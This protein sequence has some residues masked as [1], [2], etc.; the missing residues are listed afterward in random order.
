MF[1]DLEKNVSRVKQSSLDL[2]L[3]MPN[4][5]KNCLSL[6]SE[7]LN[8]NKGEII[9]IN[10]KEITEA[11]NNGLDNHVLDR[12]RLSHESIDRMIDSLITV[13][14]MPDTV[15]E[16]IETNKRNN[17]LIVNKVRVPLGVLG[18]IFE[19]R[20][21]VVIEIA[22]LAIKSGNGL[23]MR[24]GKDCIKTNLYLFKL[25]KQSLSE[26][27]IPDDSMYFLDFI[28]R[29]AVDVILSMDKYIDLLIPRGSS[30][31]VNL[32]NQ[33][34]KMPSI[35]GGVGVCHTYVD[36]DVDI[37]QAISIID[38][39][40]TQNPSVCNALDTVIIHK[41][42]LN[43]LLEPLVKN[44]SDRNVE[45]KVDEDAYKIIGSNKSVSLAEKED[46]GQEFLDL[47]VSIKT[48]ENLDMAISHITKYGSKH[49]EAIIT[50]N[51]D[52]AKYFIDKVDASAVFHNTSTR[53]ND[54][55]ELG[56]GAEVAVST[57]KLH[58]RGPM[59]I[60]D[61]MTYKWVVL[62][63]GQIRT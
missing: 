50:K 23:V 17:G 33:N 48:V 22:S 29:K 45:I 47:V 55:F 62:G 51:Q 32:V 57:D 63:E 40:K 26:S 21:N 7:K 61:L 15:S 58:A 49:S 38:N 42:I 43:S 14:D 11:L 27:G 44:L 41:E 24:G 2:S 20:P 59:G 19:S 39:A 56:L 1:Q 25:V 3:V 37:E 8:S 12:M 36:K 34:A 52:S 5:R 4:Q 46:F 6:L 54:G 18:V 60:N 9:E 13:R 30:E 35:T 16:I 31:L 28:D 10:K 53:F